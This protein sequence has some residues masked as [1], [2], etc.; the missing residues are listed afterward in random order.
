MIRDDFGGRLVEEVFGVDFM[1][2]DESKGVMEKIV[3]VSV[4]VV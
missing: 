3:R 4:S 1:G 2:W